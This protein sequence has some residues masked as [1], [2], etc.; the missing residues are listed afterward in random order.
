MSW[1]T[2]SHILHVAIICLHIPH[3]LFLFICLACSLANS[4]AY[5]Y[6]HAYIHYYE[7]N[8][9]SCLSLYISIFTCLLCIH[10]FPYFILHV[11]GHNHVCMS[12]YMF[13]CH[14]YPLFIMLC[15]QRHH[16]AKERSKIKNMKK[17]LFRQ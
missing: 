16:M 2:H 1:H 10:A 17:L 12:S 6:S 4:Y 9:H 15:S 7:H 14:I 13:S 5:I 3:Y 8:M 11:H